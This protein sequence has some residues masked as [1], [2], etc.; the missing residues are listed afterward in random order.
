MSGAPLGRAALVVAVYAAGYAVFSYA[1]FA[2]GH[3]PSA[4]APLVPRAEHY[5]VQA[6]LLVP[7]S[8]IAAFATGLVVHAVAR[9]LGGTGERT[10]TLASVARAFAIPAAALFLAPDVVAYAVGGFGAIARVTRW[11]APLTLIVVIVAMTV[12]VR[13]E[14]GVSRGRA[15]AAVLAGVVALGMLHG[16]WLR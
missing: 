1:L 14:H 5:R 13:R 6:L 11:T 8:L 9:A 10:R 12:A 4:P 16:P 2:A 15:L 7:L 3:A